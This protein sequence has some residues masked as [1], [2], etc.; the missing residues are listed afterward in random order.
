MIF[1]LQLHENNGPALF[2]SRLSRHIFFLILL[3]PIYELLNIYKYLFFMEIFFF[4]L[5]FS[6]QAQEPRAKPSM[7]ETSRQMKKILTI[8]KKGNNKIK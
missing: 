8:Y 6:K 3:W 2:A 5:R 7:H 1:A 4:F